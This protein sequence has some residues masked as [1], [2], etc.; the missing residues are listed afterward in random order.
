MALLTIG[1]VAHETINV[2]VDFEKKSWFGTKAVESVDGTA[3]DVD[4]LPFFKKAVNFND[5]D[6]RLNSAAPGHDKL[7][8]FGGEVGVSSRQ[9]NYF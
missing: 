4:K 9:A 5:V 1:D 6:V 3:V 7:T 8:F 2:A